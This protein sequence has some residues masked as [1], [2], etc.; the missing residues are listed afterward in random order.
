MPLLADVLG[1]GSLRAQAVEE[2]AATSSSSSPSTSSSGSA[3]SQ[4]AVSSSSS[5]C[6]NSTSDSA[7]GSDPDQGDQDPHKALQDMRLKLKRQAQT[8][9]ARLASLHS[10]RMRKIAKAA[11]LPSELPPKHPAEE[12]R[13]DVKANN[14]MAQPG[15]PGHVSR[16]RRLRLLVSY[17]KGWVA[18]LMGFFKRFSG[19]SSDA[20]HHTISTI[21]LDDTNMRL[22]QQDSH[23]KQWRTSRIVSV[24]NIVQTFLVCFSSA[25]VDGERTKQKAFTVHTPLV[26]LPKAGR[27]GLY[28]EMI[29][30][31]VVFLGEVSY[32]FQMLNLAG[33][34]VRSV[35]I[36]ATAMCMDAL[37]TNQAV[38][39]RLRLCI[40]KK[41]EDIQHRQIFPT[42]AV[43]C[44]IHALA[45]ARKVILSSIPSFWSS[46]VR[47]GHLFEV[48]SF[49]AQFKR[50]LVSVVYQSYRYV[51]VAELP[52]NV[53]DWSSR[54]R[55]WRR[56]PD[57]PLANGTV[58]K[59]R[60]ELHELLM[61][62]DNSD[63]EARSI[64]HYCCG[65]CCLGNCH[66]QKS[67]YALVQII[68]LY[69]TLF[70][71]GYATPLTYRWVHASRA[72]EYV[73]DAC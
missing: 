47:L 51:P 40:Q 26:V 13:D 28:F 9:K 16:K 71:V 48:G 7:S 65:D 41:H 32:R 68:K 14:T 43:L 44:Q 58:G 20:V 4:S 23:V 10:R 31:F 67:R 57:E 34:L 59:K 6:S 35:A 11:D 62:W 30:R 73:K 63:F 37:A 54:R 33:A 3:T 70:G 64:T 45:L 17:L 69:M 2:K 12:Y 42:L 52:A 18:G 66:A 53:H 50:A 25:G 72:L 1:Q 21:I 49:R 55:E 46:V 39:K 5:S 8:A 61:R 15:Q 56:I 19:D 24:M 36:Q 38:L 29:S 27:D 60:A 22:S